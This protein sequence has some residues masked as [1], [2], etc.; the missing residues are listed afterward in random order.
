MI[1]ATKGATLS[2]NNSGN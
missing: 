1:N 2:L